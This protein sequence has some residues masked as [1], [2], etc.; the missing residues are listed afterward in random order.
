MAEERVKRLRE[1]WQL[2]NRTFQHALDMGYTSLDV[3]DELI[4]Q[5][6][7]L[8]EAGVRSQFP[9]ATEQEIKMEMRKRV[10]AHDILKKHGREL[11]H[12]GD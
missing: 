8:L 5:T 11:R 9:Q 1:K 12:G 2:E 4:H 3:A 7:K 10:Q 6:L